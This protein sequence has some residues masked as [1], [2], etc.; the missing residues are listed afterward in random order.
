MYFVCLS[1]IK[2][3]LSLTGTHHLHRSHLRKRITKENIFSKSGHTSWSIAITIRAVGTTFVSSWRD[4]RAS[5]FNERDSLLWKKWNPSWNSNLTMKTRI[6]NKKQRRSK[7]TKS[8]F[9]S[10]TFSYF[11]NKFLSRPISIL[12]QSENN[13]T[14]W[15]Q[16]EDACTRTSGEEEK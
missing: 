9:Q 4:P 7:R 12:S 3:F 11:A 16:I 8:L 15:R 13:R 6:L 10:R 5:W 2:E 14:R 1:L